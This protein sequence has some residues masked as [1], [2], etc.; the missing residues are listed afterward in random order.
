MIVS[1]SG[2]M[3][4]E[5]KSAPQ[6]RRAALAGIALSLLLSGCS[7]LPDVFSSNGAASTGT[8]PSGDLKDF[9][10]AVVADEPQAALIG[11]SILTAGGNAADAAT[12]M[13][14]ALAVSLPSRAGLGGGG[15]CLAYAPSKTGPGLG[16][17]EAFLFPSAAPANPGRADRPAGVPMLARGLFALQ[18]RY[19]SRPIETLITPAEQIARNG[20]TVSRAL[21]RDIAVV[22]APLGGDPAARAVFFTNDRP[23]AEGGS[24]IQ[25]ELA[26]TLAQLRQSGI[27]DLVQGGIAHRIEDGMISAGGGLT[28]ADLRGALPR[29]VP[30]LVL[31]GV[32]K[33][34]IATLPLPEAG[35]VAALGAAQ[36]LVLDINA[37]AAANTRA[38]GLAAAV[39]NGRT[40]PAALLSATAPAGSI[41]AL[42][43]STSFAA[44][45]SQGGAVICATSMGNLFGTGRIVPGTGILLAASPAKK[46][47]ALMSIM[48]SWNPNIQAFHAMAGGSG[49]S[50]A[51]LAAAFGLGVGLAGALPAVPPEPGRANV[52]ACPRYLP[53]SSASCAWS[54]DPRS[55]GLA[56]GSN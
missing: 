43:A 21:V 27:N 38:Q 35:G 30:A 26:A 53:G 9:A 23:L 5:R 42:P 13:G 20:M 6:R 34:N 10:G 52:I 49:Q 36:L 17:P 33:D 39:R 37:V 51:P 29:R 54:V 32:G 11:R 56:V 15:G 12:A 2:R 8:I 46:P 18:A 41:G 45:D 28:V 44:L 14:L 31:T 1:S 19:G 22:A 4:V 24:L 3:S 25:L 16:A 50:S 40:D 48:L 7:S 47:Q 55:A